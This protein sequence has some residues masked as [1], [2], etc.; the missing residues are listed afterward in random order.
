MQTITTGFCVALALLL[1][2]PAGADELLPLGDGRVSDRPL[3]GD[4]FACQQSFDPDAPGAV[5]D[6]PWIN[7]QFWYPSLKP[8]IGGTVLSNGT[9]PQSSVGSDRRLIQT[10]G[11]PAHATGRFPV[12]PDDPAF[13]HDPNPN[14]ILPQVEVLDLSAT[15]VRAASPACVPMGRIGVLLTGAALFSALDARGEDAPAHELLDRCDG[16]PEVEGRYHYHRLS[17]C[18]TEGLQTPTGHSGLVGYSIDGFG[19]FGP[20]ESTGRRLATP[21]LD[22]CHGHEGPVIWDG[23]LVTIYHYHLTDDYPYSVGC[24][25]GGHPG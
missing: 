19:I 4:V 18:M 21:D 20:M 9:G 11:L 8:R 7:G 22:A 14:A 25:V 5:A 16:H 12:T 1:A 17:D 24:L 3:V 2:A 15:P 23:D 10:D 6:G 13:A